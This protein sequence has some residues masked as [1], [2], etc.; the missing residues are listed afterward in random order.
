MMT[1]YMQAILTAVYYDP[2]ILLLMIQAQMP[3]TTSACCP[4]VKAD[5]CSDGDLSI[6][7]SKSWEKEMRL[8]A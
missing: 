6:Q 1:P 2:D 3:V 4:A 5:A 8:E 7:E